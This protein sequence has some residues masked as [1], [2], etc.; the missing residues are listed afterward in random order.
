MSSLQISSGAADM[1]LRHHPE[2]TELFRQNEG[3]PWPEQA[4]QTYATVVPD[5][6]DRAEAARQI[7]R[8][9]DAVV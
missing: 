8:I 6:S 7:F 1:S 4:L 2:L 9:Q 5:H 3:T